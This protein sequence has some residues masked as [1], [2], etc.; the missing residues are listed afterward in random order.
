MDE[1]F[2]DIQHLTN[3]LVDGFAINKFDTTQMNSQWPRIL[4]Q[5]QF[6]KEEF[7]GIEKH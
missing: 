5:D 7:N 2:F 6:E 3:K 1:E 4:V